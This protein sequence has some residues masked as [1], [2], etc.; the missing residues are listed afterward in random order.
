M[1]VDSLSIKKLVLL[2]IPEKDL[3]D[4]MIQK[5]RKEILNKN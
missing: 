5:V 2:F 1:W 3:N 4:S